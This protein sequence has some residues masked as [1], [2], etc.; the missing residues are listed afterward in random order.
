MKI[1]KYGFL[2][3]LLSTFF[4]VELIVGIISNSIILQT[5]AF[6]MLSDLIAV[7]I[8]LTSYKL[9]FRDK[10]QIYT[11]GW[12]RS[13]IIGGLINSVFLLATCLFLTID[14]INKII[15]LFNN[16]GLNPNLE[17][18]ID[19]V[20]IVGGI[21]LAINIIGLFL[22]HNHSHDH[23]K[24]S[25]NIED[26]NKVNYID[27]NM[28]AL[29]LHLIGDFLG[30]IVVIITGLIIKYTDW[31]YRFYL[32][33]IIT[34]LIIIMLIISSIKLFIQCIHVLIHRIPNDIKTDS[35]LNE[36]KMLD[37]VSDVHEFHLWS[38]TNKVFIASFHISLKLNPIEINPIEIN[39]IE[40]NP[41]EINSDSLLISIK[42]ILHKYNIH[43][44]TIQL[45]YS[46]LCL[47]PICQN[48]CSERQCC[49]VKIV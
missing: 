7:I 10:S 38:L 37:M 40:I 22:F 42:E 16:T 45:E 39:P 35:L 31:E 12:L 29:F 20:L 8:S 33:P 1:L 25:T 23:D 5:D 13:E 30:S 14:S 41:I 2:I 32:D 17:N 21:G 46:N 15:D 49:S 4:L 6:H 24:P 19:I 11:Y 3:F 43:S 27:H 28:S 44:S 34:M 9:T 26:G 48:N 47:E 36:I 18:N